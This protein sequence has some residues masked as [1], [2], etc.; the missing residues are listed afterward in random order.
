[1]AVT[2]AVAQ[3]LDKCSEVLLRL[4]LYRFGLQ[5]FLIVMMS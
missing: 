2:L 5:C 4:G 1:M 3:L